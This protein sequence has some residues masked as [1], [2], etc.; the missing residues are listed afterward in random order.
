[1]TNTEAFVD[2]WAYSHGRLHFWQGAGIGILPEYR[3]IYDYGMG[4]IS[5]MVTQ[6]AVYGAETWAGLFG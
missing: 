5:A 6:K 2:A 4:R 3:C 1:M